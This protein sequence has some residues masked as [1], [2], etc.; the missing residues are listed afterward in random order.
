MVLVTGWVLLIYTP[1][2]G[3]L[4]DIFYLSYSTMKIYT[5]L[6]IGEHH[7]NHCEDYLITSEIGKNKLMCAVMDGCSMGTDSY[8]PSTLTG[9]ILRKIAKEFQ[10]REFVEKNE[11][12]NQELL[13][14]ITQQLFEQLH[15]VKNYLLL[16]R[17][18]ILNTLLLA[19]VDTS[20]KKGEFLCVG[21]GLICING[22]LIEF[23]Q[24]NRPDYLG[25]HL[26]E[27]FETWF[28]GQKQRISRAGI[29]D[30]SLSTDGIFT[31]GRF[32]NAIYSREGNIIDTLLINDDGNA[33]PNM[34]NSK[35]IE[36]KTNWGLKPA[37]D[38]AIVRVIMSK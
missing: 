8:F 3:C 25:Y 38:L 17:E 5:T 20:E 12:R 2:G 18:E 37:D 15:Y 14:L 30:F 13:K 19:I 6:H 21:D 23:E 33:S 16:E 10:F 27:N 4:T 9:K 29:N 7:V 28:A 32:D 1:G 36:I 24:D 34:L 11:K 31:F 26:S 22:E 35:M